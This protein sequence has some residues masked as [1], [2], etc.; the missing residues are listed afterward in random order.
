VLDSAGN[1]YGTTAYGG[2]REEGGYGT[3]FELISPVGKGGYTEKV[4]WSFNGN[5]GY[6]PSCGPI[7]H[8]GNLYGTT[9]IGGIYGWGVLFEVTP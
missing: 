3:V 9:A 2:S 8:G 5:D 7:L 6:I 4:L 1:I